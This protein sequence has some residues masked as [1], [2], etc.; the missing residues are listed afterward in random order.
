MPHDQ[1]Y[2]QAEHLNHD[3]KDYRITLIRNL[4]ERRSIMDIKQIKKITVKTK[5]GNHGA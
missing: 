2:Y 4:A 5:G 1:A 3:W